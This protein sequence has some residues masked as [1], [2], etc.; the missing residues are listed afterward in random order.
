MKPWLVLPILW[1]VACG[2]APEGGEL[3]RDPFHGSGA[4][5]AGGSANSDSAPLHPPELVGL[6]DTHDALADER[7]IM[8][9]DASGAAELTSGAPNTG[10]WS[11]TGPRTPSYT[12]PWVMQVRLTFEP[13]KDGDPPSTMVSTYLIFAVEADQFSA[14]VS[15]RDHGNVTQVFD[16]ME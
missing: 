6:W 13:W 5:G 4:G 1:C 9:F 14:T 12:D 2:G 8:R 7:Y 10:V 11:V 16:R 3:P 15:T